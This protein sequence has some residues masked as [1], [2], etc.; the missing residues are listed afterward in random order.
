MRDIRR[1]IEKA[2]KQVSSDEDKPVVFQYV[3]ENG[4]EQ[5]IEML[6]GELD[7]RLAEIS[8]CKDTLPQQQ[9]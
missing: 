6:S 7:E 1:R 3:D 9:K 5:K 8:Q 2:E 4:V